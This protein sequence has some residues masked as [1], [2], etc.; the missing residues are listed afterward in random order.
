MTTTQAT[1][2]RTAPMPAGLASGFGFAG[3]I[4]ATVIAVAVG[5]THDPLWALIPLGVVTSVVAFLTNWVGAVAT[6]WIC[7]SLDSG[8]VV[9]REAHLTFSPAAQFAA[10]VLVAVA[11]LAGLAGHTHRAARRSRS[12]QSQSM[13]SSSMRPQ[14][15]QSSNER[16][17]TFS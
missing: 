10:L 13:H 16:P 9:G 7:W 17:D 3:A 6:A 1:T 11:L 4:V 8:F 12:V 14:P 15:I 2:D 5:S